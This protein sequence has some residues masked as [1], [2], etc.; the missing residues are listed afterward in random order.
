MCVYMLSC[1]SCVWLFETLWAIARQPPLSMGFS[2][3]EYWSGLPGPPPGDLPDPGIE[4]Q[5]LISPIL[6]GGFFTTSATWEA[7]NCTYFKY[8]L[9]WALT[10]ACTC[11]TITIESEY[12]CHPQNASCLL[13][14]P[15]PS[16][17]L[18]T[19]IASDGFLS[20]EVSMQEFFCHC[21][22]RFFLYILNFLH[23]SK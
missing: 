16:P 14:I 19:E 12:T 1:F 17:H 9:W 20:L 7:P 4:P 18:Y 21:W 5:S 22:I 2:R 15:C 6:A 13:A 23:V 3:Q 11:E 8:N 10:Y